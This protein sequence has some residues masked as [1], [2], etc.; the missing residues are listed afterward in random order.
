LRVLDSTA[1]D[2]LTPELLSA[3]AQRTHVFARV[4]PTKKL[5]IV[6][7]LQGAGLTVGMIGDGFNDA[8]ALKAADIAIAVGTA[9]AT[10]ARDVA[11]VVIAEKGLAVVG[12]GIEQGR[13]ILSNIRKSVHYLLSTNLSEILVLLAEVLRQDDVLES[14]MELLWLNLVTDVL[15]SLG[16][17][18][19]PPERFVMAV[20]PRPADEPLLTARDLR[21]SAVESAVIAAATLGAHAYGLARYGPGPQTRTVTF[22]SLVATQLLHALACRHDRFVPLGG[23]A[24]FGNAPLNAALVA[25]AGLQVIP[26]LSPA[27]R[28][29]LGILPPRRMD[30]AVAALAGCAA[31]AANESLLAYRTSGEINPIRVISA[32]A[33]L[34]SS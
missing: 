28:G 18:L 5:H 6:R 21:H 12:D 26:F 25:S 11:D 20:P 23:R 27:L 14:P 31:F 7:A 1:L 3:I 10:A 22:L 32:A 34:R 13:T 33:K 2:R 16:L 19:E 4:P 17:A 8:P 30:L 29:F 15:P 9:S 24:L